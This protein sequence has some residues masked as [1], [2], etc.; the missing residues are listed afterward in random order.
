MGGRCYV[1]SPEGSVY[2]INLR[3]F[4]RLQEVVNQRCLAE[5]GTVNNIVSYLIFRDIGGGGCRM[6]MVRYWRSMS[7]LA[8]VQ[9]YNDRKKDQFTVGGVTGSLEL[10]EVDLTGRRLLPVRSLGGRSSAFIGLTHCLLISTETLP[11]IAADNIYLGCLLQCRQRFGVYHINKV[12][13][14]RRTGPPHEFARD[15]DRGLVPAAHPCNLDQ[16]LACYVD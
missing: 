6:M 16:Y 15:V 9:D 5:P 4:P 2:L 13:N 14:R 1:S 7:R 10:L 11:S 12:K 3:P 8:G